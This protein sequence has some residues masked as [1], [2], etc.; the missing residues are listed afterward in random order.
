[1]RFVLVAVGTE[2]GAAQDALQFVEQ[3]QA[4]DH[5]DALVDECAN[6]GVGNAPGGH[7]R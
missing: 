5:T 6:D 4:R 7:R 1:V 2:L 3:E